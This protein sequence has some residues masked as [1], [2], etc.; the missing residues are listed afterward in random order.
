M[1]QYDQGWAQINR[2]VFHK[3][4]ADRVHA[5]FLRVVIWCYRFEMAIAVNPKVRHG[6][7]R[8]IYELEGSLHRLE[9]Q[10]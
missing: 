6:L 7:S 9:V 10:C 1:S 3:S 5:K 4:F 8:S 2:P